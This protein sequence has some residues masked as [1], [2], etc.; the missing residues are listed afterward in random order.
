MSEEENVVV[1]TDGAEAD[2]EAE[3]DELGEVQENSESGDAPGADLGNPTGTKAIMKKVREIVRDAKRAHRNSLKLQRELIRLPAGKVLIL[4]TPLADGT[5]ELS[6]SDF[7]SRYVKAYEKK[8]DELPR[9]VN[10][11]MHAK[12]QNNHKPYGGFNSPAYFTKT[13]QDFVRDFLKTSAKDLDAHVPGFSASFPLL[14]T[15]GI[16]SASTL[17]SFLNI[18][19]KIRNLVARA[20]IN[21]GKGDGAAGAAGAAGPGG[22]E[23]DMTRMGADDLMKK[24]FAKS[25]E[26]LHRTDKEL[27]QK[28]GQKVDHRKRTL[29]QIIQPLDL[30]NFEHSA[31][32]SLVALHKRNAKGLTV[33]KRRVVDDVTGEKV[34]VL[35]SNIAIDPPLNDAEKALLAKLGKDD[36]IAAEKQEMYNALGAEQEKV[37]ALLEKLTG[38]KKKAVAGATGGKAAVE[39]EAVDGDGADGEEAAE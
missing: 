14:M 19:A 2:A 10:A 37:S 11:A 25:F 20:T 33:R 21:Q 22:K 7:N 23:L 6:L 4:K 38:R 32:Q 31:F 16:S 18:Y 26:A 13:M 9:L 30:N 5:A 8:L 34:E 12:R 3:V 29:G 28:A 15:K 1:D 39:T 35:A 27:D 17:G 24:Y 36:P